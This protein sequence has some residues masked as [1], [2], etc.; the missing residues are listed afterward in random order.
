M[1]R[2]RRIR[3]AARFNFQALSV[4]GL[5]LY[6]GRHSGHCVRSGDR[7]VLRGA[8]VSFTVG[9]RRRRQILKAKELTNSNDLQTESTISNGYNLKMSN[10]L[11]I[12]FQPPSFYRTASGFHPLNLQSYCMHKTLGPGGTFANKWPH[13]QFPSTISISNT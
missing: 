8:I 7:L 4:L 10:D 11:Q 2:I 13:I 1:E 9:W 3:V 12:Q 5:L 6:Y